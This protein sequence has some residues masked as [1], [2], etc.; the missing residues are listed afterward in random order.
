MEHSDTY[1][2]EDI[3]LDEAAFEKAVKDFE[4][5]ANQMKQLR[6]DIESMLTTL[7]AGFDTPAGRRFVESCEKNLF[8]PIDA[9]QLVLSHISTTISESKQAYSSVFSEYEEL[10]KTINEVINK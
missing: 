8:V 3:I 10:Q 5:L 1:F 6:L 9:Q 7:K 2:S 4:G